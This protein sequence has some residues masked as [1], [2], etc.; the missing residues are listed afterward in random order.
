MHNQKAWITKMLTSN[1]F[2]QCFIPQVSQYLLEKGLPFKILLLMDNAGG[3]ATDLSREGVQVEFLPPN[4]TSLIQPMDQGVIRA[5]KAL[6][7]KNTLA[8]LVAC[9]DAAQ[10]DEDEDFNLKAYWR[11]YTI[12]TCLQ[13]IQKALQE[14]KPATVNASWKKLWPDIVYDDKGFTPSEIQHSAIRKSVQL[15]AIIGGDGFGD[16]TTEDVDELLDCHSQP[17]TDADLE[18]LTKSASEEESEGTQEETQENVEETGLTLERLAKFCNHMKEAKEML[19][20]WDEDMVRSMQF[21]NKVDDI[22]TPYRM[23]LDRKKKQRQ[24]LPITMFFQPRKK[25][26]V[27]PASTPSEEI[28]EVE[29]T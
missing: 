7:T 19:Q 3:H 6:Y 20:E 11:Q 16:M 2:H 5:F 4:T 10:D 25:E 9:V 13:N 23:L 24:Q 28:E 15:A 22:T 14:M 12:A 8:D 1:W 21:C 27:P 29:E 17:L 26:P 18:D